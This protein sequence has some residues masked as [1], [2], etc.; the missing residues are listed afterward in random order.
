MEEHKIIENNYKIIETNDKIIETNNK[1][2]ETN[3]KIIENNDKIIENNDKIIENNDIIN[4]NSHK[5]SCNYV[6]YLLKSSVCNRTYIGI[7]TNLKKRLRQHNG[8][9]CGGAK[10]TKSNRPWIPILCVSGFFTKNQALSFEYR[11]KK[12]KNN[13]NKLVTLFLL[14]NRIQNFFDVL[15]LDKF[16]SKCDNPKEAIYDITC[17]NK[18]V[19]EKI[20]VNKSKNILINYNEFTN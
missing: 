11:V 4:L 6:C 13:K 2:I 8:E 20:N 1:I 5:K 10:Y 9:I 19:Y 14:E 16:T 12:K 7:S 15:K 17:F 3:D 18:S